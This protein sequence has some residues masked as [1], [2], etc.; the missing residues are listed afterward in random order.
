MLEQFKLLNKSNFKN[1]IFNFIIKFKQLK[2]NQ[3]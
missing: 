1:M 2:D 3:R